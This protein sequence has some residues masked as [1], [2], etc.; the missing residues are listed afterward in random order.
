MTQ[1][2]LNCWNF[3][4]QI[5]PKLVSLTLWFRLSCKSSVLVLLSMYLL[6]MPLQETKY[7]STIHF[8]KA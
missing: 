2:S 1:S 5:I 4:A 7:S 3:S 6:D 8:L